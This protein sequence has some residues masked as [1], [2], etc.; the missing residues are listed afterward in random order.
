M[1]VGKGVDRVFNLMH[2]RCDSCK[3]FRT[4]V[5]VVFQ[6]DCKR[7]EAQSGEDADAH[8]IPGTHKKRARFEPGPQPIKTS[9]GHALLDS[10]IGSWEEGKRNRCF[11]I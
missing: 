8:V 10:S 5:L 4:D 11:D 1:I 2:L 9:C 7:N 6:G 3:A